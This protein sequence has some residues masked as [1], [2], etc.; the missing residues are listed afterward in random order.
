VKKDGGK[1]SNEGDEE[2]WDLQDDLLQPSK[3]AIAD[4]TNTYQLF[5]DRIFCAPQEDILEEL[6]LSLGSPRLST[7]VK[8]NYETSREEPYSKIGPDTRHLILE[9]LPLFLH[10]HPQSRTKVSFNW[11]NEEKNFIVKVFGKL[12]VTKSLH[13]GD[14]RNS[15]KHEASAVAKRE[16]KG[17]IELWL[18]GNTQVDM[19]EVSTS[20]CRFIFEAPKVNDA[21]LF[22]TILSTDLKALKRRG[23]NVDR[24]L[25][26]Q[27]AERDAAEKARAETRASLISN[28]PKITVQDTPAKTPTKQTTILPPPAGTVTTAPPSTPLPPPPPTPGSTGLEQTSKPSR[29]RSTIHELGRLLRPNRSEA[30]FSRP[31][32]PPKGEDVLPPS[33]P[34]PSRR[35]VSPSPNA[36]VPEGAPLSS[37]SGSSGAI[38]RSQ[39]RQPGPTVT[40]LSNIT[41]NID[42][43]IKACTPEKSVL[44][45]NREEMQMVKESLDEGY[46]DVTGKTGDLDLIGTMGGIKVFAG[47]ELPER[48]TLI[49]R[50]HDVLARFLHILNPLVEVYRIPQTSLHVFADS[51]GQ[52]VA[53]NRSG[54]LFM[55]LRYY[56]AWHD[57]DVQRGDYTK[58][59]IS[60]Y[61]TLAHEIAHNL[62]HPHNSEH[63]FYF[64]AI[65]E[66][67]LVPLSKLLPDS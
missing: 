19:Y 2:D 17:P 50:K 20:L 25:R 46:C 1:T 6:Y 55:N 4:D 66:A 5:G 45:R 34:V 49:Q 67:H 18:A 35:D 3:V 53:F 21:L 9:R 61:F 31:T 58:A 62:V 57:R 51:E 10:E 24:I 29:P 33:K 44:L 36:N 22:M 27:K 52:L 43:A 63:E 42:M 28:P 13:L 30:S 38:V 23:Y 65:C 12:L 39:P 14:I 41:N 56:E 48:Q 47:P 11:L 8:E 15:E 32:S 60:W 40:P 7:L 54:S 16:G 37:K 26:Q 64:S 59:M